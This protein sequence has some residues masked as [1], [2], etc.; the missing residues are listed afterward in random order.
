[1]QERKFG[2][3]LDGAAAEGDR[4]GA[5]GGEGGAGVGD[6]VGE[7]ELSAL[8]DADLASCDAGLLESF[9]EKL[10]GVFVFVPGVDAGCRSA[11]KGGGFGFHSFAD[12]ALF[13]DG[14]DDEGCALGREGPSEEAFGLAPAE[15]GEIVEGSACSDDD[16][17]DLILVHE[18][19]CAVEALF[20]LSEGDGGSFG[21]AA[22]ECGD[23]GWEMVL[24]VGLL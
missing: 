6:A 16:G 11:G 22:G 7:D 23:G 3:G 19:A 21:A 24:L 2:G 9:G 8:L 20:A 1:L 13:E 14:A 5:G 10:V 12:S 17:I 15:A 18:G 4:S